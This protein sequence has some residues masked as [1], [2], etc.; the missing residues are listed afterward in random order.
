MPLQQPEAGPTWDE[1]ARLPGFA[2]V[3]D[4]SDATGVKNA[5]IDA[6]QKLALR[7]ALPELRGL[8][9]L[10]LGCGNGRISKW[11]R[12]L[13]ASVIGVD[14]SQEM[15]RVARELVLGIDFRVGDAEALPLPDGR[16]DVVVSVTVLQYLAPNRER[17]GA[18]AGEIRRVLRDGGQLVAIEHVTDGRLLRGAPLDT[19]ETCFARAGLVEFRSDIVRRG[20]SIALPCLLARPRLA[21]SRLAPHVLR[22][23]ALLR[24]GP[25]SG[26]GYNEA[27][28]RGVRGGG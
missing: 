16:F 1:R 17:L 3:L 5:V 2:G 11:L 14:P 21:R 25:S 7:R 24:R 12:D 13:G 23:E 10:D 20:D 8:E 22:L 19:Y 28:L 6:S 18:A 26:A 15:I 4:A 27:V 9:V